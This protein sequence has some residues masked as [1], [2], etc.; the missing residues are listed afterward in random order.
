MLVWTEGSSVWCLCRTAAVTGTAC[1][2]ADTGVR[3]YSVAAGGKKWQCGVNM[4]MGP[5]DSQGCAVVVKVVDNVVR[6]SDVLVR[7][8][9][10]ELR[11]IWISLLLGTKIM[12]LSSKTR[13]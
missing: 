13:I 10:M 12:L 7:A 11:R 9:C 8:A 2:Q 3:L 6:A 1:V 5:G 4:R